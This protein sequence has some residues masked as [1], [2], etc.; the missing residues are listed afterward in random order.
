MQGATEKP[1]RGRM[2]HLIFQASSALAKKNPAICGALETQI[3]ASRNAANWDF[4][5]APTLVASTLPFLNNIRVGYHERHAWRGLPGFHRCSAWRWSACLCKS[6]QSRPEPE[7]SFC[8]D[9]TI[10]PSNQQAQHLQP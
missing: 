10:Q 4:D 6:R 8:T 7:R 3:L 5:R 1:L 2:Y 9:H